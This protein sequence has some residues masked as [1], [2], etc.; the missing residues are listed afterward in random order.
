MARVAVNPE[1]LQWARQRAGLSVGDLRRKFPKVADWLRGEL[2]PTLKQLE[3][4]ARK[5][6]TPVGFFFLPEPPDISLPIP[7]FRTM[8][9]EKPVSPS[10]DLLET[11]YLCQQRQD[12]YRDY[13]RLYGEEALE[14]IGSGTVE[15]DIVEVATRLRDIIGFDL[16]ERQ[17]FATWGDALRFFIERVEKTGVLV[18]VSGIVGSNTHRKLSPEEFRGFALVDSHAPVI[19]INGA[20]SK[21]AQMFTLTHELT[22]LWLGEAGVS[23]SQV[24]RWPEKGVESWCNAVAAELLI[25]LEAV[26]QEY[27]PEERIEKEIQRLAKKFKVSTLVALRRIFDL[28]GIDRETL[29]K[30]YNE[31]LERLRQ[32]SKAGTGGGDFYRTLGSRD[33][34]RFVRAVI[35]STLEG[36]TL[37]RDAFR[38]LG[39]RKS[40]TFYRA[41]SEFWG[42]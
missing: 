39:I 25:P 32:L 6:H 27:R 17:Q 3:A 34:K 12:W 2:A 33:S 14:W 26:R 7:D 38:L 1:I 24:V 36:Q 10:P 29:W 35:G 18:M 11:I 23:D 30:T 5:T 28:G 20:D 42:N 9:A 31:E 19:F 13:M 40:A 4:F 22:H 15:A 8:A 37:F 41:A 21:S 16:A